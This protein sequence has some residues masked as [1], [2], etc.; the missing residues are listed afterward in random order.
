[1]STLRV[2]RWPTRERTHCSSLIAHCAFVIALAL[3][4]AA[5]SQAS[6]PVARPSSVLFTPPPPQQSTIVIPVTTSLAPLV[7]QVES[8]VPKLVQKLDAY[9]MDPEQRFGVKYKIVRDPIVLNM[10]GSGLHATTTIHYALQGCRRTVN[11]ITKAAAMWPCISCGFGEPMR[12]AVITIDSHLEWDG[13][14]RLRSVTRAR[15]VEFPNPCAV[16][17]LNIDVSEWKIGPL[18]DQQLRDVVKTIDRATPKVTNLRPQAQEIWTALQTP[19]EIAPN[20]WLLLEPAA[21]GLGPIRG[22]GQ[23][24]T[25]SIALVAQ[26]RVVVGPRPAVAAKPLPP[27]R[28]AV[29]SAAGL[30]VPIDVQVPYEEAS[31]LLSGEF[32]KR[33]YDAGGGKLA[34][35]AI[36]LLPGAAGKLSVEASIDYRG[37][38]LKRYAG[39]VYLDGTPRFDPATSAM[40]IDDVDYTLD[41]HRHNPF[42]RTANRLVHD[43]L[44]STL[45][46]N[47]RW[48]IAA[49]LARVRGEIDRGL[50]RP[51]GG[52]AT[53]KG[54]VDALQPSVV[55]AG[56]DAIALRVVATGTA[57]IAL[58]LAP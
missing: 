24:V 45:R 58:S 39:L 42:L 6:Q 54:H 3:L 26:T 7:P 27:L 56:P 34:V 4:L 17:P 32:A 38:G 48:S 35:N 11:P 10:Q 51:L 44:R 15:P 31:R 20:T 36:R 25:S 19:S 14:W 5:C 21:V 43:T 50:N 13:N 33:N 49:E 22:S 28:V 40:V 18:A 1:M 52:G 12:Q 2:R 23:T 57:S 29:D 46:A 55:T 9:E 47:A 30:H 8:Q 16:T 41:P 53:L 37:G